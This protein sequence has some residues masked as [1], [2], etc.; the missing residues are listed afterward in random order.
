MVVAVSA[1][2]IALGM[3][4][5][6]P[7]AA[8]PPGFEPGSPVA[9]TDPE[10]V[11]TVRSGEDRGGLDKVLLID[12][13]DPDQL[14]PLPAEVRVIRH[15][16]G[17]NPGLRDAG[18]DRP[19][20]LVYSNTLG[21]YLY[22]PG[23][24][25]RIGDDIYTTSIEPFE[26]NRYLIRVSG[27]VEDGDETFDVT[28]VLMEECPVLL[29]YNAPGIPGT[30]LTFAGLEDDLSVIHELVIDFEDSNLGICTDE[31]ACR[32]SEQDCDDGSPCVA[33]DSKPV[34]PP[35][36]WLRVEFS[37][38]RAG[39]IVGMPATVGYSADRYYHVIVGCDIRFGGYP[40]RPHASFYS[41][42]F[43]QDACPKHFLAYLAENPSSEPFELPPGTEYVRFGDDVELIAEECEL[44][45][46]EVGTKGYAG[47]YEIDFDLRT[48]LTDEPIPG[49]RRTFVSSPESGTGNLE[50]ARMTFEPGLLLDSRFWITWKANRP[51]TGVLNSQRIRVGHSSVYCA[52]EDPC[53]YAHTDE[54]AT[55]VWPPNFSYAAFYFRVYCRG[56]A[57]LGACCPE[58]ADTPNS[59]LVCDDA[60]PITSCPE[61]RW[62]EG[63]S[64]PAGHG[65]P[66]DPWLQMGEPPCG[67]QA[68]CTPE[69]VCLDIPRDE[70]MGMTDEYGNPGRWFKGDF[71]DD[72]RFECPWFACFD[73]QEPCDFPHAGV[74]CRYESCCDHVCDFDPWCCTVEWDQNCVRWAGGNCATRPSND[75]CWSEQPGY[76]ARLVD[77]NSSTIVYQDHATIADEDPSFCC[78]RSDSYP[79]GAGSVWFKFEATHDTARIST[80][81]T[82]DEDASDSLVQVFS[83][84]DP[85]TPET[86]CNSLT[87]IGCNDDTP[88]CGSGKHSDICVRGL[89]PGEVYYIVLAAWTA[90][91]MGTHVLD[92]ESPC[93]EGSTPQCPDVEIT[94]LDPPNG[95]VDARRPY[96]VGDESSLLGI[97]TI[98]IAAST[99]ADITDDICWSICETAATETSN[100]IVGITDNGDG[101]YTIGLGRAITPGAVTTVS[102][103]S[104][105]CTVSRGRFTSLP[106]DASADG[107]SNTN[108]ILSLID[109]CLNGVCVPPFGDYSCDIGHTGTVT[110]LDIRR[111][112]YL[113]NGAGSF[114]EWLFATPHDEGECP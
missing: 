37:T 17:G 96:P 21:T 14:R 45:V 22:S 50:I 24:Y 80:C 61:G 49:S 82:T 43:A 110:S 78:R 42:F 11:E 26:L 44:S 76:G 73:A 23:R 39:W 97:D 20:K 95:V 48:Y 81:Q 15:F 63:A 56:G 85:S 12:E 4:Y 90:A 84:L 89:V 70:C 57:P 34:I 103:T 41:E 28:V 66:D 105:T 108:D 53:S 16:A 111:L 62:L 40:S 47:P 92:I 71:C 86:S 6:A 104:S 35:H 75:D 100:S 91:D 46:I 107:L 101:T 2:A 36:V 1:A 38:R 3:G 114:R 59:E 93:P 69:D 77:A 94:W 88:G 27:G 83:V 74:G 54:W 10:A 112:I 72:E 31:K 113:L 13:I 29:P 5:T 32:I 79:R 65:D 51:G 98:V 18:A 8:A 7:A 109:C 58:Q 25:Y 64:C 68:C 19:G 52:C 60:V 55:N 102:Y 106:G 33:R 67:T 9:A 30:E 87:A 99:D